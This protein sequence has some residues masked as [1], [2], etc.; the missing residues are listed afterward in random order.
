MPLVRDAILMFVKANPRPICA[1]CLTRALRLAFDPLMD[2]WSD[3]RLRGDLPIQPGR[4]S[5]CGE[6]AGEVIG[7]RL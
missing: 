1:A 4:C 6:Q 5:A 7:P 3:I 2:G